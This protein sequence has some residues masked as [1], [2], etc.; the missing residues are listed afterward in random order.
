MPT[1]WPARGAICLACRTALPIGAPCPHG[2]GPSRSLATTDGHEALVAATWGPP[3]LRTRALQASRAGVTG[4]G[5]TALA[6]CGSCGA[7]SAE[8]LVVFAIAAIVLFGVWFGIRALI[9]WRRRR[10]HQLRP[11]PALALPAPRDR[12]RLGTVVAR[13]AV[14]ADPF[15]GRRAVA[16]GIEMRWRSD[17]M[18]RDAAALG[19]DIALDSGERVR[20]P[21]GACVLDPRG[22][23]R[24]EAD[25][26]AVLAYLEALDPHGAAGGEY[27][28]VPAHRVAVVTLAAGDRVEVLGELTPIPDPEAPSTAYRDAPPTVLVPAGV[29]Q[30]R[31]ADPPAR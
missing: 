25:A 3:S 28:A 2:H 26:P 7:G 27:A 21:P 29:P 8:G 11:R 22:A 10:R 30:L 14:A 13:S 6:D 5:G 1:R 12:G 19:F 9:D 4:G 20:I 18:L 16:Y 17:P 15:T 31:V 23:S 24:I